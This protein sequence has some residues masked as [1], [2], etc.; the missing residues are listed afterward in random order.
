MNILRR[1]GFGVPATFAAM[2]LVMVLGC[3]DDSGLAKRYSVSGTVKYKGQ[4]VSKGRISFTPDGGQGRACG[5]DIEDGAY[6]L[7]TTGTP[8]DGALPGKYKV[9]I[10]SVEVDTTELRKIAKGG[11]FHHDKAFQKANAEAKQ[12]VPSK[13][14]VADTSGLVREVE[15]KG[16]TINFDLTD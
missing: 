5:G 14:A 13:Y 12:L 1:S 7:S 11:Q 2:G 9:T 6:S 4:P 10:T 3:G 15:A 8:N 16:N